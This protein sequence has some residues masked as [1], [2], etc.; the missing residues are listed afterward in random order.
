M[1]FREGSR[2]KFHSRTLNDASRHGVNGPFVISVLLVAN[3]RLYSWITRSNYDVKGLEMACP[4]SPASSFHLLR[5]PLRRILM[6]A[7]ENR[8]GVDEFRNRKLRGKKDSTRF[9]LSNGKKLVEFVQDLIEI[10][11]IVAFVFP[12]RWRDFS[13]D[14]TLSTLITQ[15]GRNNKN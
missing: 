9:N 13:F 4:P 10:T 1:R 12:F 3:Y 6:R 15:S 5:R 8:G 7:R 14:L 2:V 11:M